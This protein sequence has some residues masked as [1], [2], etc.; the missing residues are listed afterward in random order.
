M[1]NRNSGPLRCTKRFDLGVELFGKRFDNAS[2]KSSFWLGK[3]TVLPANS[4]VSNREFSIRSRD[5][6][7]NDDFSVFCFW[8][9]P[10]FQR[11]YNKLRNNQSEAFGLTTISA[12]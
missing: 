1:R 2:A 8:V 10:I 3:D 5:I 12:S 6:I 4:V 9:K 11:I 7:R